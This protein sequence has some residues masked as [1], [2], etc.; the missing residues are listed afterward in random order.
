MKYLLAQGCTVHAERTPG[1]EWQ[2]QSF[3]SW[4]CCLGGPRRPLSGATCVHTGCEGSTYP[5]Q[6]LVLQGQDPGALCEQLHL[7]S[8]QRVGRGE[9]ALGAPAVDRTGEVSVETSAWTRL[10][11]AAFCL[12]RV[13]AGL[14]EAALAVTSSSPPLQSCQSDKKC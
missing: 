13:S 12:G 11:S 3:S 10:N 14:T 4:Q 5:P 8:R 6:F 7:H 1:S 9:V 2:S